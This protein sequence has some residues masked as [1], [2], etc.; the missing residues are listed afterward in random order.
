MVTCGGGWERRTGF[1]EYLYPFVYNF[2]KLCEDCL[3]IV[4]MAASSEYQTRRVTYVDLVFLG[5]GNNFSVTCA[6]IHRFDSSIAL[7]T[8]LT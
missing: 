8:S 4:A 2:A 6:I 3:F 7:L 5:P 1:A